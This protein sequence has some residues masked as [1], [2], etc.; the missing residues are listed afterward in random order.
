MLGIAGLSAGVGIFQHFHEHFGTPMWQLIPNP[1]AVGETYAS[2]E[3]RLVGL[4]EDPIRAGNVMMI[5]GLFALGA[6]LVAP[7]SANSKRLIGFTL[8]LMAGAAYFTYTR[9]WAIAMVPALL[10]IAFLYKGKYRMEFCLIIIVLAGGF[11]Y[12]S[13]TKANRYTLTAANDDSAAARPVLWTLGLDI[14]YDHPW[15]GVGH[16]AFLKL[17]PE[18]AKDLSQS[19]LDNQNAGD[20][21]GKYAPHNDLINVWLSWGFFA[22]VIYV[23]FALLILKNFYDTFLHARDPLLRGLALGGIAALLGYEVNSQF[24]NM[25]DSTLTL[26]IIGGFSLV[27]LKMSPYTPVEDPPPGPPR[28]ARLVRARVEDEWETC[29]V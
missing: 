1:G 11:W 17:S 23:V 3:E 2:W 9:S 4:S 27:M 15:L 7:I 20:V 5:T 25:L 10:S 26:W 29:A 6:I 21:V 28:P 16:D 8:L 12:W 24:H 13:D 19:L 18:Y 14:A 22:L